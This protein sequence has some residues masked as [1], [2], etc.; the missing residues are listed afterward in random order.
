MNEDCEYCFQ[1]REC[2]SGGMCACERC[3]DPLTDRDIYDQ[4][5][6]EYYSLLKEGA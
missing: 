3:H 4:K 5:V 6:D 2:Y 1:N